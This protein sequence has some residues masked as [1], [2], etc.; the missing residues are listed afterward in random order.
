MTLPTF[1]DVDAALAYFDSLPPVTI[2]QLLGRWRGAGVATG[3][4]LDGLLETF[5]WHGKRFETAEDVHPLIFRSRG[6]RMFEVAPGRLPLTVLL[7]YPRTA[8][9]PLTARLFTLAR[10]LLTTSAPGAR[11]RMTEY[12]GVVSAT[13]CYD[14]LPVHDVFRRVDAT[15]VLGA[16]DLR[17]S[18]QPL[19]FRLTRLGPPRS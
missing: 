6:G 2:P 16:M 14:A 10:P 1:A 9:L 13:M 11:L 8:R 12:R 18:P 4:P 15:T 3:H 7:R 17:N 5:G 19:V